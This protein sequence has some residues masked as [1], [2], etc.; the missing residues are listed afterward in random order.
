MELGVT[1]LAVAG[2]ETCSEG[3]VRGPQLHDQRPL[4]DYND[5][6][7]SWWLINK[8]LYGQKMR[9]RKLLRERKWEDGEKKMEKEEKV[10]G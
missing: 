10:K 6:D 8:M 7:G 9:M 4:R 3:G 1:V 5:E 2:A